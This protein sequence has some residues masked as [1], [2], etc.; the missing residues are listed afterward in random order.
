MIIEA[1]PEWKPKRP[2]KPK[3]E[4]TEQSSQASFLVEVAA[5]KCELFTDAQGEAYA[6]FAVAHG[7]G[8]THRE[9]H[10]IRSRGF[11][12]WLRLLYYRERNGA[13]S[14]EAMSSAS[15]T[16]EAKAHYDGVRH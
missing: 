15:K 2:A 16:I 5:S 1:A 9:T 3:G 11:N 4:R 12:R 7:E 14:S 13:P 8:E 6:S 10:K